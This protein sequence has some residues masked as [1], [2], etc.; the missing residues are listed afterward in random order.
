MWPYLTVKVKYKGENVAIFDFQG[1]ISCELLVTGTYF[2]ILT[3]NL[4]GGK[5]GIFDFKSHIQGHIRSVN[6]LKSLY[7]YRK[8]ES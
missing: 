3:Y 2:D 8:Y 4:P 7:I 1:Q 6:A 5:C